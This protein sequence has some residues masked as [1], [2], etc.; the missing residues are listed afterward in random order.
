MAIGKSTLSLPRMTLYNSDGV[1]RTVGIWRY[2][3]GGIIEKGYYDYKT[4]TLGPYS[5]REKYGYVVSYY[6]DWPTPPIRLLYRAL[7]ETKTA[8]AAIFVNNYYI[9][10]LY[11]DAIKYI[12][13]SDDHYDF[14]PIDD[15]KV[16]NVI[17]C[18]WVKT[19]LD[20]A[21][22]SRLPYKLQMDLQTGEVYMGNGE[23]IKPPGF[24]RLDVNLD[25]PMYKRLLEHE[26][27]TAVMWDAVANKEIYF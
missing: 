3:G 18:G 8:L 20:C 13:I 2:G 9:C 26:D 17:D 21:D 14:Y 1:E 10:L 5:F 23:W 15:L 25:Y 19:Y 22:V 6:S 4:Q 11:P 27:A 16:R 7:L 12:G 24:P